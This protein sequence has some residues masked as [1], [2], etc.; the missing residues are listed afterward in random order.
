MLVTVANLLVP[1]KMDDAAEGL[2]GGG[3]KGLANG[4]SRERPNESLATHCEWDTGKNLQKETLSD[5][6]GERAAI[7]SLVLLYMTCCC[8]TFCFFWVGVSLEVG[9][10]SDDWCRVRDCHV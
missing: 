5:S 4:R 3:S 8:G 1:R 9:L 2:V 10:L 6:D 7:F